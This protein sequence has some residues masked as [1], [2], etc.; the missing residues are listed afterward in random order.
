[1]TDVSELIATT[2]HID[3]LVSLHPDVHRACF[4]HGT[5]IGAEDLA[6]DLV[7]GK[8]LSFVFTASHHGV[9]APLFRFAS[10]TFFP[11]W[12]GMIFLANGMG[13]TNVFFGVEFLRFRC[14][15]GPSVVDDRRCLRLHYG[16]MGNLWPSEGVFDE[17]R[18][19]NDHVGIGCTI[20]SG[21]PT[22]WYGLQLPE[23]G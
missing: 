10:K 23:G 8:L 20:R 22:L 14:D 21:A 2:R 17:V 3:D 16:G 15:E 18:R 13:G 6:P 7:R 9:A 12:R 5:M 4:E 11:P 19:L 1:M